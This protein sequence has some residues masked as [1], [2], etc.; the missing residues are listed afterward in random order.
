MRARCSRKISLEVSKGQ[1]MGMEDTRFPPAP[2]GWER[3]QPWYHPLCLWLN[4]SCFRGLAHRSPQPLHALQFTT[5]IRILE[6]GNGR[7][8]EET[9]LFLGAKSTVLSSLPLWPDFILPM[10]PQEKYC[11][12]YFSKEE[13]LLPRVERHER[14]SEIWVLPTP[15]SPPPVTQ[16]F[17][18]YT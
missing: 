4:C 15:P 9:N 18:V 16:D 7:E 2:A 17:M 14:S 12:F 1:V 8:R 6:N 10:C 13:T 5:L 3:F 11:Y